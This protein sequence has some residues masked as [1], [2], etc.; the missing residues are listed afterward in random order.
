MACSVNSHFCGKGLR[1]A[2][3][4]AV[5]ATRIGGERATI[6]R[7][8]ATNLCRFCN[9]DAER[10]IFASGNRDLGLRE[11]TPRAFRYLG[12]L[13]WDFPAPFSNDDVRGITIDQIYSHGQLLK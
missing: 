3:D 11:S 12:E 2:T 1:A 4:R 9:I 10:S 6:E 7:S 8:I 13:G 5:L